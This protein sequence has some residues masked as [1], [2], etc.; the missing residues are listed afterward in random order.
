MSRIANFQT[1]P[2]QQ[3][4]PFSLGM[5]ECS[6]ASPFF[7]RLVHSFL[8]ASHG[9]FHTRSNFH[10]HAK[11]LWVKTIACVWVC[12]SGQ[13]HPNISKYMWTM[14]ESWKIIGCLTHPQFPKQSPWLLPPSPA[15]H[16]RTEGL[17][18]LF[19]ITSTSV[20]SKL[21]R[22]SSKV[23][24]SVQYLA[25]GR[26]TPLGLWNNF[27]NHIMAMKRPKSLVWM[28]WNSFFKALD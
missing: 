5:S 25:I 16:I 1:N 3:H 26:A 24:A 6:R 15:G 18:D 22:V 20:P 17:A 28:W 8:V 7:G 11:C 4:V 13:Q 2:H 14:W 21:Q 19:W 27:W 12:P 10:K 23:P 9:Q